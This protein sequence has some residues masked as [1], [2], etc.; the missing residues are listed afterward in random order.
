MKKIFAGCI[1]VM[2]FVTCIIPAQAISYEAGA[3]DATESEA[4]AAAE[5][6]Y[7]VN[8]AI[9]LGLVPE[10][11]QDDYEAPIT[12]VEFAEAALH[13]VA[14][15]Y[16]YDTSNFVAV[17]ST[18]PPLRADGTEI[19]Y[20]ANVFPDTDGDSAFVDWSYALGLVAEKESGVFDPDGLITRQE[21]AVLLAGIAA[22][23]G[24]TEAGESTVS[25]SDENDIASW[26]KGSVSL[27]SSWGVFGGVESGLFAPQDVFTRKQ[28]FTT[29]LRL[30]NNAPV[31][32][33][34]GNVSSLLSYEDDIERAANSM[35]V[36][37]QWE[38]DIGSVIY[39]IQDGEQ[40]LLV[41][42]NEGG[43]KEIPIP[44]DSLS[45]ISKYTSYVGLIHVYGSDSRKY[46]IDLRTGKSVPLAEGGKIDIKLVPQGEV[47][48]MEDDP[49]PR[50][51]FDH[52]ALNVSTEN[53]SAR[54]HTIGIGYMPIY[55]DNGKPWNIYQGDRA[56][57]RVTAD[58]TES[59][60]AGH[61]M[62]FGYNI[63]VK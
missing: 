35:A 30:Y 25:F 56:L 13:F 52:L 20:K 23:Y 34:M 9:R 60:P 48:T 22:F 3:P 55:T 4:Y 63:T 58:R 21:A 36:E 10:S 59:Y 54:P 46:E 29:L 19:S 8:N 12:R 2:L 15:Q 57:I 7:E 43:C 51:E 31:S 62:E 28:C 24:A 33:A 16:G 27:L 17:C 14:A 11:L 1:G 40:V 49:R 50:N 38:Y 61:L 47:I 44:T 53:N 26:A 18:Y 37:F 39:G 42:Y 5:A 6:L 32:R 45:Y 41:I